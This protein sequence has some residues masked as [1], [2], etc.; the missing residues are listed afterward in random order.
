MRIGKMTHRKLMRALKSREEGGA[1]VETAMTAPL[2]AV[3]ILGSVE[4]AR[5]A[6]AAIEVTNAARAGV[7]Y[8]AQSGLTASDTAGITWAATHDGVNIPGMSVSGVSLAY[9]C[10]DGSASTGAPSDCPNSHLEETVTVQTQVTMNPLVH[11]PGLP[12][13]YTLYGSAVQ[14]CM[15]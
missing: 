13:T 3:L 1:L 11:V 15:Q 12:A 8:G 4:F 10:S 14:K 5:V 6:Y 2:L 9:I 7:S